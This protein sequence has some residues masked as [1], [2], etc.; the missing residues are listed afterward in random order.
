MRIL[1]ILLPLFLLFGC[2]SME[3]TGR[4]SNGMVVYRNEIAYWDND[5]SDDGE[6]RLIYY[7]GISSDRVIGSVMLAA[8][9]TNKNTGQVYKKDTTILTY[10]N[11]NVDEFTL[12]REWT[13]SVNGMVIAADSRVYLFENSQ[14]K[15]IE[16]AENLPHPVNEKA[17]FKAGSRFKWYEN[18]NTREYTLRDDFRDPQSGIVFKAGEPITWY[19]NGR[20]KRVI[21]AE[22]WHNPN[23]VIIYAAN[24]PLEFFEDG[25]LQRGTFAESWTDS[26]TGITYEANKEYTFD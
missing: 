21:L 15:S 12:A 19:V 20:F 8:N 16:L 4:F 11:G 5:A 3:P 6:Y 24:S 7:D 17:V 13:D 2:I 22:A 25:R 23:G 1:I 14:L 10:P 18:G 9:W 26:L